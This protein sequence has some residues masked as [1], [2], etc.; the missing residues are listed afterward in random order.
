MEPE[1]H[2]KIIHRHVVTEADL[3]HF[4]YERVHHICSTF[5]LAREIEW[6][7]RQYINR[8][9]DEKHEGIGTMLE[10]HHQGI[11]LEGEEMVIHAEVESF[12]H[13]ELICVFEVLVG[14]RLVASGKTGQKLLPRDVLER[15]FNEL[16]SGR[17]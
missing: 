6:T 12:E 1:L 15:K 11:A 16:E 4:K 2:Q 17:E 8:I 7:T 5:A 10:V 13:N 9:K 14:D 3:A